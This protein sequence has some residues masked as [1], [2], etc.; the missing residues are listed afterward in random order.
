MGKDVENWN[1]RVL[2]LKK[3]QV[4]YLPT[5][6]YRGRR[7]PLSKRFFFPEKITSICN[8]IWQTG[9]AKRGLW[10]PR[11]LDLQYE[12]IKTFA[13]EVSRLVRNILKN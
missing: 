10:T 11:I 4:Q 9:K 5:Y 13:E 6:L 1:T 8:L 7:K 12:N 2:S 3:F